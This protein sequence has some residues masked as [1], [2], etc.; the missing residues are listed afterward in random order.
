MFTGD[1]NNGKS[2]FLKLVK[3]IMGEDNISALDLKELGD[4]FSTSMVF[5]KLVNIGDD[6]GDDFLQG[7]QVAMFK[8]IVSGDRIK[9]ER[10][11][12]DPFEFDPYVKLLF[13]ANDIPRMKDKTGAV[14]D[15]LIII[16]FNARFSKEDP[17]YDPFIGYKLIEPGS[18]GYL[19]KLGIMGL[20]RV[21]EGQ[22]FTR[23]DLVDRQLEEYEE[24]NN[25][26][27]AFI[28]DL[29]HG[30]DDIVN[31]AAADVYA[32]YNVFCNAA[33]MQPMSKGVFSKQINKRIGTEIAFRKIAG[34][35]TRVFVRAKGR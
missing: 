12:Q 18:I 23:S 27:V 19:I 3:V 14:L 32:R 21:L 6:I 24:E 34:K 33:N 31:E 29:E 11:G 5:G 28:H 17:D 15:R 7:T 22:G 16:P 20:R 26:I 10:K 30:E 13:S 4:R 8:K 9:A 35:T 2:T 1:K 25:P